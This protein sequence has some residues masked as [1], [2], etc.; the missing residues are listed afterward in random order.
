MSIYP[1]L[2]SRTCDSLT[3]YY[4]RNSTV[5]VSHLK[6]LA[7]NIFCL[8]LGIRTLRTQAI[9]SHGEA[10]ME[11]NQGLQP[12]APVELPANSQHQLASHQMCYL[13]NGSSGSTGPLPADAIYR[14]DK[15]SS[16]SHAQI[17][18]SREK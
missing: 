1:A 9:A 11:K 8:S 15:L 14:R 13:K 10:P 4:G 7:V 16:L 17:M 6:K 12:I 2:E 3:V 5:T 18:D